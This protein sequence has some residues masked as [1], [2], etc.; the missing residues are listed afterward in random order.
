MRERTLGP[1]AREYL[2]VVT[3]ARNGNVSAAAQ[4]AGVG[5][6]H[7]YRLLWRNGLK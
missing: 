1:V 4:T 7:F 5:R 6:T 3:Q 2:E